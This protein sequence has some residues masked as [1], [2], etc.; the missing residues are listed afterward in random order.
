MVYAVGARGV[1]AL[2]HHTLSNTFLVLLFALFMGRISLFRSGIAGFS[3]S[4]V[5]PAGVHRVVI[6][7]AYC[8]ASWRNLFVRKLVSLGCQV[9]PWQ[10]GPPQLIG[11]NGSS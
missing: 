5:Y 4:R 10:G 7:L 3:S 8:F 2:L 6:G 1:F 9:T 11:V